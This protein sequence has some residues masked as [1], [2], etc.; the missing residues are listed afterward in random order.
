VYI[1]NDTQSH[2]R[3]EITN[4]GRKRV[5]DKRANNGRPKG[6]KS[7]KT[8]LAEMVGEDFYKIAK[9]QF[10][11][12]A[13]MLFDKA[14]IEKDVTAAKIIMDKILPNAAVEKEG[15]KRKDFGINII[16]NDMK[17]VSIKE[18]IEDGEIV[19]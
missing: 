5:Q 1:L 3:G 18:D 2:T 14:I 19:A 6:A 15:E 7:K 9:K 12:V 4:R 17:A 16:I 8:V 10:N 13:Q 11:E